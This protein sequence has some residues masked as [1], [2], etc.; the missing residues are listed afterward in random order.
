MRELVCDFHW[1]TLPC[2]DVAY[3][4]CPPVLMATNCHWIGGVGIGGGGNEDDD[5][6]NTGTTDSEG[7]SAREAVLVGIL[8][9]LAPTQTQLLTKTLVRKLLALKL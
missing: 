9:L 3:S 4:D 7:T 6:S 2:Y 5:Y 8:I 1:E